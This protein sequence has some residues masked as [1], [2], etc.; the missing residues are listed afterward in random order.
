MCPKSAGGGCAHVIAGICGNG[1]EGASCAT[2]LG[3]RTKGVPGWVDGGPC[4]G[5]DPGFGVTAGTGNDA[6]GTTLAR[7]GWGLTNSKCGGTDGEGAF[8][9]GEHPSSAK[10]GNRAAGECVGWAEEGD[11]VAGECAGSAEGAGGAGERAGSA[12]DLGLGGTVCG[13]EASAG[14]R[15]DGCSATS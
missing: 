14:G 3:S 1:T 6:A 15:A 7:V 2:A 4:V 11:G 5:G 12:A 13:G 9:A 10:E 8:A